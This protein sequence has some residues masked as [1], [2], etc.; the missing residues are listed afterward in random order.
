MCDTF[1]YLGQIVAAGMKLQKGEQLAFA[2]FQFDC[3]FG[4]AEKLH[5]E[6]DC[7]GPQ[8]VSAGVLLL[9]ANPTALEQRLQR[10]SCLGNL[11]REVFG[12]ARLF[13]QKTKDRSRRVLLAGDSELTCN[14][15]PRI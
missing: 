7:R 4:P 13:L 12:R 15:A 8:G 10:L 9:C 3:R 2:L 14:I 1:G 11:A 5:F 6:P